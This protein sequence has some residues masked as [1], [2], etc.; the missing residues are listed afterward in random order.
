MLVTGFPSVDRPD[1]GIFNARAASALNVLVPVSVVHLR[2]W[3]PGLHSSEAASQRVPVHTVTAPQIPGKPALNILLFRTLGWSRVWP[4]IESCR[5]IHS[6]DAS[7]A[8]VLA[9]TWARRARKRHVVQLV[10]SDVTLLR[11]MRDVGAIKGWEKNVHAVACNSQA[12]A[13]AFLDLYPDAKNVRTVRRGVDL[14]KYSPEGAAAGP[15]AG[16][17]PVR[18]LFL[19]GFPA[20]RRLP[21][22]SNTKGGWTLLAAWKRR[23][24]DLV[25]SGASLLIAGPN[26]DV[27]EVARWRASLRD[28]DRV[29]LLGVLNPGVVAS[30]MRAAEAVLV[31]SL[32][33][34]LPNVATEASACGKAVF[35]SDVGGSG[36]VVS[37]NETGLLL[38]PGDVA[39][40]ATALVSYAVRADRLRDM[41]ECA[42]LRMKS[43]FDASSYARQMIDLYQTALA[44][45]PTESGF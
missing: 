9:S 8:G 5:V 22:G 12:L 13:G 25:A 17:A 24:N 33:E 34:G 40:W 7:F 41:G 2:S 28:P 31:P 26:A 4:L 42:R 3:R 20:Y 19:G 30:Y 10:G 45:H 11:Q 39:A 15:L 32:E 27:D 36:E 35:A 38:P 14:V 18:Y 29:V 23:E 37:D 43:F 21:H 44:G 6:V 1:S 16:A